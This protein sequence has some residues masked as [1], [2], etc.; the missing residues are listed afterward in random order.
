MTDHSISDDDR[1][2]AAF[3]MNCPICARARDKQTGIAYFFVK[4]VE[5]AFCPYCQ[6]YAKVYG[7]KA[8]EPVPPQFSDN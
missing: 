7:R 5:G 1:K 2:K 4:N 3:C 6:A 8:H